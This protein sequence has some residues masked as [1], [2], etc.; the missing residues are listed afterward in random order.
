VKLLRVLQTKEVTPLG[1]TQAEPVDVRVVCAT[2]RD[3]GKLQQSGAFRGDLFARLN[4]FSLRLLPL[5]ARKEDLFML[6]QALAARHGRPDV[7]VTVAFMA[8]LVHYDF[9]FN[10]R[11][12]EALIKR[13]AVVA[14]TPVLDVQHFS[15]EFQERAAT[16]GRA[17]AEGLPA[18]AAVPTPAPA[19][20]PPPAPPSPRIP[21]PPRGAPAEQ[22]LRALLAEHRGNVAVVSRIFGKD[23]VQVHRWMRRYGITLDEYR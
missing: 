23:R 17:R 14:T 12:L 16:Y 9:P 6:C 18:P 10:V 4:E 7:E 22:E 8:G 11:E 3:L 1:A 2:H 20:V 5:R 21:L 19:A 13:W 15:P